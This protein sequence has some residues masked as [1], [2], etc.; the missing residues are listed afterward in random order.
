VFDLLRT[1][2][3]V[4]AT[5]HRTIQLA[6]HQLVLDVPE[7]IALDGYPG[8]YGQV[9]TNLVN[10][11]LLHGFGQRKGGT[12]RLQ[13]ALWRTQQVEIRF[14]DDGVGIAPEHLNRIFDPFFTTK[15]GQGGSGLGMS[16]SYN[17]VTSLF[18]GEFVVTS[19]V[20]LGS[21]FTLRIPLKAPLNAARNAPP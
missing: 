4:I 9:L 8:P 14:S 12:M 13:A 3:E 15:M 6:G 18:G 7:G 11:A 10:N 17:I 20:G 5:L 1:S 19:T 2:Q 16:I 21:C